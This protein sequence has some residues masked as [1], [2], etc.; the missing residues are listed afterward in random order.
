[1]TFFLF[2]LKTHLFFTPLTNK[3]IILSLYSFCLFSVFFLFKFIFYLFFPERLFFFSLAFYFFALETFPKF[4]L[5][6]FFPALCFLFTFLLESLCILCFSL[7]ILFMLASDM[8]LF[9]LKF[10]IFV[11]LLFALDLLASLSVC[12]NPL[13]YCFVGRLFFDWLTCEGIMLLVDCAKSLTMFTSA[14]FTTS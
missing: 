11:L 3:F 9:C 13:R 1:M 8:L 4:S 5:V 6:N 14:V 2:A 10:L 7:D 12:S